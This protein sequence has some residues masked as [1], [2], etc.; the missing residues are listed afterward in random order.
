M[1]L[2]TFDE[3]AAEGGPV[4]VRIGHE[5][6]A[7]ELAGV[8]IVACPYGRGES[9]GVLHLDLDAGDED[10]YLGEIASRF[11]LDVGTS[12]WLADAVRWGWRT[13]LWPPRSWTPR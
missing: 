5:N 8:S 1:L 2:N 10:R 12:P 4:M 7:S 9:E 6:P 11:L 3:A 13:K